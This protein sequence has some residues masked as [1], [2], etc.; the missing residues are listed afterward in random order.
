MTTSLRLLV[1]SDTFGTFVRESLEKHLETIK[2][3][4][5]IILLGDLPA[6]IYP[7]LRN[8]YELTMRGLC[9]LGN[10]DGDDWTDW[11]PRYKFQHLHAALSSLSVDDHG[12]MFGGFSGSERYKA[13]GKWQWHNH[14]AERILKTFPPC[15]ILMTHTTGI[16]PDGHQDDHRHKGLPAINGYMERCQPH[17]A[18]HGHFHLNYQKRYGKTQV[19]GC[20]GAVLIECDISGDMWR[21]NAKPITSFPW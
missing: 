17:L 8:D 10:H 4:H 15:D 3:C 19:V 13:E 18:F 9:V 2:D 14:E 7:T 20:Y 21:V 16:A 5:A 12:V 11:L 1:I 6:K